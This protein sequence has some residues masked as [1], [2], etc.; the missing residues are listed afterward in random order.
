MSSNLENP[1]DESVFAVA[2]VS[3]ARDVD[4]ACRAAERAFE[5]W[6]DSTPADRQRA[7]LALADALEARQ[8]ELVEIESLNTGKPVHLLTNDELPA[9]I[10]AVRYFAGA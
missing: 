10:D 5:D 6:R 9:V 7:L 8:D 4:D 3:G 2:P 1:T